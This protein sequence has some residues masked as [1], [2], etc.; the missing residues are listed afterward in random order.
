MRRIA[1]V[2]AGV[3]AV[4]Q[5]LAG[6]LCMVSPPLAAAAFKIGAPGPAVAALIRIAGGL[7]VVA[8]LRFN[9]ELIWFSTAGALACY[10]YLLGYARWFADRD[11]RV[12]RYHQL[13]FLLAVVLTGVFL[14]QVIRRVRRLAEDYA[15]RVEGS[16]ERS[17]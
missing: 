14:G 15:R 9:L 13:I 7:L 12:P 1:R 2:L 8:A 6:M 16:R 4:Y 11:I 3:N 5:G 17:P 10:L